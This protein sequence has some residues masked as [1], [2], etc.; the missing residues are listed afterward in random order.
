MAL[1]HGRLGDHGRL[2][3]FEGHASN[4]IFSAK[5][6]CTINLTVSCYL[7]LYSKPCEKCFFMR[8]WV[9]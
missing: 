5:D 4:L 8:L 9:T 6:V 7:Y 2:D 1:D 3:V